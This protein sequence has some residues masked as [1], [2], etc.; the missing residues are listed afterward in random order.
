[1]ETRR[2]RTP[3]RSHEDAWGDP[4]RWQRDDDPLRVHGG[5]DDDDDDLDQEDDGEDEEPDDEADEA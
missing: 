3:E 2:E 1:M 4:G 5:G